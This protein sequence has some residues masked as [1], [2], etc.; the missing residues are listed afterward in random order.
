MTDGFVLDMFDD[1]LV[2]IPLGEARRLA[3]LNDA[4]ETSVTW[5][6]FL[7]SVGSDVE[8]RSYLNGFI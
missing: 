6:E 1:A 4:L 5:G 8:T 7:T 2:I 3:A